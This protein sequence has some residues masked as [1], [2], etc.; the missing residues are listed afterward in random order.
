MK[1]IISPCDLQ[2]KLLKSLM[3]KLAIWINLLMLCGCNSLS[4]PSGQA[5]SNQPNT[6]NTCPDEPMGSLDSKKVKTIQLATQTVTESG[7]ARVNEYLGYTFEAKAG[8]KLNYN[9]DDDICIWVYAP[10]NQLIASKD[11]S[12]TG[13]Y[14]MQ[15]SALKGSTTFELEMGF[16]SPKVSS[17][18]SPTSTR[19]PKQPTV[20]STPK[21]PDA[22][23]FI[24]NHYTALNNRLYS[25]TWTKLS[26]QFK[27]I[28]GGYSEYTKWWNS[29]EE[30]KIGT[31]DLI[32]QSSDAAVVDAQLRYVMN[33]GRVVKDSK[34]RIYLIW[35]S[36]SDSWLFESKS[37]P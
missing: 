15:V 10:D 36:E 37:V 5:V 30:I 14:T 1:G 2:N 33:D 21:R 13:K 35:S 28:A 31:I 7:Q 23:R 34:S 16:D 29:V 22:D 3:P 26:P 9:T 19:P 24:K 20:K 6:A 25:S 4:N 17:S 32:S 11:L 8:Q 12:K 18:P 27:K